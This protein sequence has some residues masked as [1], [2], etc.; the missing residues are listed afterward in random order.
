MASAET[1]SLSSF[2][3]EGVAGLADLRRVIAIGRVIRGLG[4]ALWT[5]VRSMITEATPVQPHSRF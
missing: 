1:S 5:T 4:L 3:E 2:A